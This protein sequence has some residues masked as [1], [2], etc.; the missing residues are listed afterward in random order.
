MAHRHNPNPSTSR[1]GPEVINVDEVYMKYEYDSEEDGIQTIDA[2]T[3]RQSVRRSEGREKEKDKMRRLSSWP[4][5][6]SGSFIPH[7][8]KSRQDDAVR[9]SS[10]VIRQPPAVKRQ[11]EVIELSSDDEAVFE[12]LT[13]RKKIKAD[14][15]T[16]QPPFQTEITSDYDEDMADAFQSDNKP[17]QEH[18]KTPEPEQPSFDD[19]DDGT[20]WDW[21]PIGDIQ[22]S[23]IW[24]SSTQVAIA[25]DDVKL[26][27]SQLPVTEQSPS[28]SPLVPYFRRPD[29]SMYGRYPIRRPVEEIVFIW[30]KLRACDNLYYK[31]RCRHPFSRPF[32]TRPWNVDF[33]VYSLECEHSFKRAPGCIS[34]IEQ[35][36][37][38]TA[39][40]TASIGG[41]PDNVPIDP[42]SAAQN[43]PGSLM[44]WQNGRG[45][46]IP[47]GHFKRTAD[48]TTGGWKYKYY[49]V[50]DVKFDPH[51]VAFAST[52]ADRKLR[53]WT[54]E[55]EDG[56][57]E[58]IP[59]SDNS[60][61][62]AEG[63]SRWKN[64]DTE[65]F[66][67]TPYDIVFNPES[68]MLA[69]AEKKVNVYKITE[70]GK[71]S[72]YFHLHPTK[73]PHVIGSM[74]WGAGP[75]TDILFASSEPD[76]FH[77]VN[78]PHFDGIHAMYST[79]KERIL[80][81]FDAKEAGDTL[82]INSSGDM[83][84]V[85]TRGGQ[86]DHILR[87]YD[88][89]RQRSNATATVKLSSFP[90]RY[91]QFEGEVSCASFS[92]DGL[93]LAMGRNDNHVHLYDVRMLDRGPIFDYEHF[94]ESLASPG[95]GYGILK[96]H[97]IHSE[98]TRRMALLSG[99]E[100]GCVRIW[101]PALASGD[102]KKNETA[103]AKM[104]ADVMTFS[105]GDRYAGE[106]VLV[107]G[108]ADGEVKI[109]ND[110]I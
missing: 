15:A 29:T 92:P 87:L 88:V 75:T 27:I 103:I 68:S 12:L 53:I 66:G 50:H 93:Y 60:P 77:T 25:E 90:Q 55:D 4:A 1:Q 9:P 85:S 62:E 39:I 100:D 107:V 52:G 34:K 18:I 35:S 109:F 78:T 13:P 76:P 36:G 95:N 3:F 20:G 67:R 33:H 31:R 101:D 106:H 26:D 6:S 51:S 74:A 41:L 64:S 49:A 37:K 42:A 8:S 73:S 23:D 56:S 63:R 48:P 84:A 89:S 110:V 99:G 28:E 19:E 57:D 22:D 71:S 46:E 72:C 59:A 32:Y 58:R 80:V 40:G 43:Q 24:E 91:E 102:K 65:S 98:Q 38:W 11:I 83:L 7:V 47:S 97:W 2:N 30:D 96:I 104:N 5:S 61:F 54:L 108:D 17:F 21:D 105:Y 86:N 70:A 79:E 14:S 69:V 82:A 45:L 16:P 81:E 94:G 44:T 10:A